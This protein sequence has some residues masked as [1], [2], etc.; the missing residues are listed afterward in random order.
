M[1]QIF[2]GMISNNKLSKDLVFK[3][4]LYSKK[5]EKYYSKITTNDYMFIWFKT[6]Y[7]IIFEKEWREWIMKPI[8]DYYHTIKDW[9]AYEITPKFAM[10]F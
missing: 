9:I 5:K 2:S 8:R 1:K 4:W 6:W 10:P 7:V 3:D